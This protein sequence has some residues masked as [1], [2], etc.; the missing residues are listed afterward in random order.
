MP[1]WTRRAVLAAGVGALAAP[2]T[3]V[4][5][6]DPVVIMTPFAFGPNFLEMINAHT[7]GHFARHGLDARL[8]SA[9]GTAQGLQQVTA[10]QAF[11]T[12]A[13]ALDVIQ[14]VARTEAPLVAV[15]TPQQGGT[16]HVISP[17]DRPIRRAE[18]F[19]G[20]TIG[21]VS[22]GG[23]TG[24]FLDLM[25]RKAGVPNDAV[26]REVTGDNPGAMEL[27]RQGRI[28]GF[29]AS[30]IAPIALRRR[31]IAIEAWSTDRYAPMPGQ[32]YVVNRDA[33]RQRPE[34][35]SR[36]LMALRDSMREI[37]ATPARAIIERAA[38]EVEMPGARDMEAAVAISDTIVRDLWLARG[39]DALMTNVPALWAEAFAAIGAG[40]LPLPR[41]PA[42]LWTN[43]YVGP[44]MRS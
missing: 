21:I 39:A 8:L 5:A 34:V 3:R 27:V 30:I 11:L 40:G 29:M 24:I 43:D 41:D 4:A 22:V 33:A 36:V 7:G 42:A 15:A 23:S 2:A 20:K 1:R 16:F 12:R 19:A 17:A 44:V 25:L 26:R 14:A 18:E 6:R 28:D 10:G 9:N 37:M 13:S 32:C 35:I 31:G 38:R